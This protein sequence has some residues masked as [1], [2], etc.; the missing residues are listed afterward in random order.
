MGVSS[1]ADASGSPLDRLLMTFLIVVG[2]LTLSFRFE[3]TTKLL[4]RNKWVVALFILILSSIIWSNFP[5][6]SLRRSIRSAGALIMVLVVLTESS[7]GA[8]VVALLKRL[9]FV[10]IPLSIVAIKYFRHFAVMYNWDGTE[11][12]WTGLS[13]DKNSLG[14][15]AMCSGLFCVWQIIQNWPKQNGERNYKKLAPSMSLLFLSLY[16]LRGS[17]NVHSST[18]ILGF[19]ICTFF[20]IG[21]QFAKS[22]AA[23]IKRALL[24]GI[25]ASVI[26]APVGYVVFQS[27]DAAPVQAVF[28]ATGRDMT[29]TD[30]TLI[31]TD[32]IND[33]SKTPILGIGFGAF[34]VGP[35]GYYR[36]PMP[37]WSRKTP[38]WRPEEGHNGF[39]DIYAQLGAV[40]LGLFLILMSGGLWGALIQLETDFRYGSLRLTFLLTIILSNMTETSFLDGTHGLWF[41]FLLFCVSLPNPSELKPA[42]VFQVH[43]RKA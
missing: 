31:W 15:V 26:L 6:I 1:D 43:P 19:V 41:L 2:L 37:N 10:H 20:L 25:A 39:V 4:W 32:V 8:A 22:R 5:G 34:W 9:Y 29:F 13:I 40:G 35:I 33:V 21:L 38:G 11:E 24:V 7:P 23:R 27:L 30:R 16:L 12:Q 3:Q 28:Q 42:P 17:K 18:A 36:Y 14:H